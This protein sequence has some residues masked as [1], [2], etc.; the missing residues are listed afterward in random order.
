LKFNNV[1][2]ELYISFKINNESCYIFPKYINC[3][4][5]LAD[6]EAFEHFLL[7]FHPTNFCVL[8]DLN[9]RTGCCHDLDEQMLANFPQVN[10]IRKSKDK[11]T[12][13]KGR[14]ILDL[15]DTLGGFILNGRFAGDS[16]GDFTFCGSS[17]SSVIDY[18]VSSFSFLSYIHDFFIPTKEFSDHMPLVLKLSTPGPDISSSKETQERVKLKWHESF[19]ENFVKTLV[20]NRCHEYIYSDSSIDQ[21]VDTLLD[22]IRTATPPV[23]YRKPF[24]PKNEWF[25]EHCSNARRKMLGHLNLLRR[26]NLEVYRREYLRSRKHYFELCKD[27]KS[28]YKL[29]KINELCTVKNASDWW[30][31]ANSFKLQSQRSSSSLS[32]KDFAVHFCALLKAD[33][34][35]RMISWCIPA[36]IDPYLDAPF[37][38]RELQMVLKKCKANKS[39]GLDGISYEFYVNAPLCFQLELLRLLNFIFL[40]G[41]IP[42][43]FREA[44]II[45]LH[46]KGDPNDESNYRG[47]SLLNTIYKI[48]TAL[49]LD[50]I[51]TWVDVNNILNEYQAGFRRNYSTVDNIFCL[52]SIVHINFS[53]KKKTYA[54]FV[55]FKCAFDKLPRNSLFYKLTGMGLSC[56]MVVIL[57]SIYNET[58]SKIW[59]GKEMSSPVNVEQGVKQGCLLSPLLFSLYLNDLHD[60]LPGGLQ[61]GGVTIKVLMYADD[62]V[63]LSTC[64]IELQRMI[65]SLSC[66]CD[67][68]GLEVNLDKSKVMIF[69][70]GPRI[71]RSLSFMYNNRDIEIVNQYQY[72]GMLLTYNMSYRK[73]IDLKLKSAKNAIN[74]NWSNF[75]LDPNIDVLNKLKIFNVAA[76]SILLYDA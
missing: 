61:I 7:D 31:S 34:N 24:C 50:R 9:A 48:F 57:M 19:K 51:Q 20:E 70:E 40:T 6:F 55:D 45:P 71:S 25:D 58:T 33:P 21:K 54:F 63:L 76:K 38:I 46:K 22:K 10:H 32:A 49:L 65:N 27:K 13:S 36:T 15:F 12:D 52:S 18:C 43:A 2:Q 8:G 11:I 60:F 3:N 37:E 30:K 16:E 69:R 74:A 53:C 44:I 42:S 59:N 68:W 39:P 73:H 62:I 64:P 17:G 41:D 28:S 14:K 23:I 75:V 47:L 67:T 56:K 1:C 5:W 4:K 72:L 29:N 35:A 26:Y 66:Y